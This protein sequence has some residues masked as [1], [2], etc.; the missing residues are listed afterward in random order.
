MR[1]LTI[2]QRLRKLE[3]IYDRLNR[4]S[5]AVHCRY[6]TSPNLIA[7][8]GTSG[9]TL[10]NYLFPMN[11]KIEDAIV[12]VDSDEHIEVDFNVKI[13]QKEHILSHV[14]KLMGK[15]SEYHNLA[16]K[17]S[18]HDILEV[19]TTSQVSVPIWVSVVWFTDMRHYLYEKYQVED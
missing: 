19:S 2:E 18:S 3:T 9:E 15:Y 11:G 12:K 16:T 6:F 5:K 13:I 1:E 4:R 8:H 7:A 14:Y 17:I 10:L